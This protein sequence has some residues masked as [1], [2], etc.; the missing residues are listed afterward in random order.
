M[1]GDEETD[2]FDAVIDRALRSY[3]EPAEVPE[4]RVVLTRVLSRVQ[5]A[6]SQRRGWWMW[7]VVTTVGLAVLVTVGVVWMMRTPRRAEIAWIPKAPGMTEGSPQR[8]KPESPGRVHGTAEAVSLQ[9]RGTTRRKSRAEAES[10]PK[11][12]VFPTPR[13][14]SVEEQ[15]LVAFVRRAPPAVKK[16]V[17][18]DQ[19]HWDDPIIVA[20]LRDPSLQSGSHKN[21]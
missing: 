13:P 2:R 7:G 17:I 21:Q 18:E 1:R 11:K 15:G 10:P 16:A 6:E 4:A 5:E 9:S 8:L 14:L 20:D 12:E 19:Q 3:S